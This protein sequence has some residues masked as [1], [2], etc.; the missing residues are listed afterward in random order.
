MSVHGKSWLV[1]SV[2][3]LSLQAQEGDARWRL[4]G[5]GTFGLAMNSADSGEYLRELSQPRGTSH[6]LDPRLDSRLGLQLNYNVTDDVSFV[7]Q[8]VSKYRYDH[9]FTPDLTW[10][11]LSYAPT[12]GLQARVG[13]LGWDV[14]QL[15]DTRNVGYSY[16]WVR[17]PVDFYGPLQASSLDGADLAWTTPIGEGQSL[18]FKVSAGRTSE[19]VP[20]GTDGINLDL[21]GGKLFGAL[22]EFQ[23]ENL[24]LRVAYAQFHTAKDFPSSVTTLREGVEAFAALLNDPALDRQADSMVFQDQTFHYYSVGLNWQ[25][26]PWR[27]E[28]AGAEIRSRTA[29]APT[30]RSGYASLGYRLGTVV[31]YVLFS[32]LVT[33][34]PDPYVGALPGL[35]PQGEALAEGITDF[36]DHSRANQSTVS[37]GVRWDVHPK[38][39]LKVQVDRVS[40]RPDATLLWL[41]TSPGWDGKATLAAIT[42]DFVF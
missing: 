26:G 7:G 13:R 2:L 22:A 31:P 19:K 29:V 40:A 38:A 39:A 17:P 35:G 41:N 28:A 33:D 24:N 9:T 1:L 4:S 14:F 36:V 42:L 32:R 8:A 23:G 16:L 5:F 25:D 34:Q 10:A 3:A 6:T 37:L 20:L 18:R 27:V 30:M 12:S 21:S 15:S 11:F